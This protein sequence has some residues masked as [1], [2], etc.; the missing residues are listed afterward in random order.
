[1]KFV[2]P[3]QGTHTDEA[4]NPRRLCPQHDYRLAADRL[5]GFWA[6]CELSYK[7]MAT[8]NRNN[9][10]YDEDLSLSGALWAPHIFAGRSLLL[11]YA[12]LNRSGCQGSPERCFSHWA[13]TSHY[14]TK[15][16]V[17]EVMKFSWADSLL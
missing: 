1:M 13:F 3:S 10:V 12:I 11:I 5:L 6:T 17:L 2:F 15:V 8:F 14:L 4:I 9:M 16:E 7:T